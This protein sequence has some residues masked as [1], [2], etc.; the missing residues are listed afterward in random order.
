MGLGKM[1]RDEYS[2][3]SARRIYVA[4]SIRCEMNM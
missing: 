1:A 2:M 4:M 3:S